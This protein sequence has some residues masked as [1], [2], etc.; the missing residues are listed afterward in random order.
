MALNDIGVLVLG[1]GKIYFDRFASGI[2]V[3]ESTTGE[4]E[5][6]F[7]NTPGFTLSASEENLEHFSSEGGVRVKD[8]SVQLSLDRSGTLAC[9]NINAD[10]LALQF[11]GT[12]TLLTQA[13]ATGLSTTY[14]NVKLGRYLQAGA[15]VSNPAGQRNI[16]TVVVKTGASYATTVTMSGN[17]TVDAE[18]G[19]IYILPTATELADG[20][21]VKI[22]FAVAESTR[23]QVI[24]GTTSIY[25]ALRYIA[26][27]PSGPN[28]DVYL[29]YVKMAPDGD[30]SFKGEEWMTCNF[31][32]EALK[33][34][35]SI[36]SVYIDGR[37]TLVV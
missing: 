7:G 19:R 9:D 20:D 21:D 34:S 33:K 32:L 36:E 18:L 29:P 24:S 2:T 31:T 8:G 17:Y 23:E 27:N 3:G 13:A 10:N 5:R 4:G 11:L 6:Y 16:L 28:R 22:E 1:K 15:S 12:A 35:S 37:P 26:D 30:I 14:E 25:G